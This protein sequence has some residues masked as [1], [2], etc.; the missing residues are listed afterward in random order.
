MD[1]MTENDSELVRRMSDG[2]D[3]ALSAIFDRWAPTVTRYAWALADGR[4]DVEEIVQDTFVTLWRRSAE[5]TL[6][7][8]SLL[9]WLLVA[10]RNH[11]MNLRRKRRRSEADEL[12]VDL[13]APDDGD[14]QEARE[15]LR[16]VRSEIEALSPVDRQI[17]E[18]CLIEGRSYA[19]AAPMLGLTVGAL[20]QRVSR[21]RTR[22][23]KAVIRDG[24]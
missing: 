4:M 18:L 10:C 14:A 16:G 22:L 3:R 1:L 13:V 9:P 2:D 23:K 20:T 15:R 19:E 6:H 12:P 11:A 7:D 21:T 5:I 17:C 8:D 24:R